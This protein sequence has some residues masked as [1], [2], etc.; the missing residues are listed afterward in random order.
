[1]ID[2]LRY[3]DLET[4]LLEDVR[5]RF[6]AHGILSAFDFF[7]IVI[8]KANRAKSKIARRLLRKAGS[9]DLEQAVADLSRSLFEADT[10]KERLRILMEDWGFMLPMASAVLAVLWPDE[11]TVY[12]VR[13]CDELG[14]FHQL[15]NRTRFGRVWSTYQEFCEAVR[16]AGPEGLS[17]RDRDR[18]LWAK[19]SATQLQQD[20]ARCFRRPTNPPNTAV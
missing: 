3:Y 16:V 6:H 5:G 13:A 4:Y 14:K 12:D 20:I 8:W 7:S 1:M 9:D 2:Y 19:S 10:S 15:A 11:F 17:L 18:H